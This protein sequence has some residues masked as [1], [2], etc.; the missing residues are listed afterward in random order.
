MKKNKKSDENTEKNCKVV[1][2]KNGPYLVS[3]SLP[4]S[5]EIIVCDH[6]G[7]PAEWKKGEKYPNQENYALCRCGK[8][9]NKPY[10]DSTHL[11]IKF[12]GTE[13]ASRK[14]YLEQAEKLS[15]PGLDLTDAENLCSVARFCHRAGGTWNLTGNSDN[16]K[17]K[18]LAIKE[19]C[20]CPSGRLVAWNKKTGKPI[21]IKFEPSISLAEE[22]DKKCSGPIRLKGGVPLESEN[23]D[24]YEIRNR[25]TLCRCGK[26]SNKPFCDGTHISERFNDGDKSVNK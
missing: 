13:T 21:E 11:K 12:N 3:G 24:K 23:G 5:K 7:N 18:E 22:P 8:S 16:P 2:S 1:V 4:L 6:E 17:S 20:N 25:I 10:C 9:K 19:A 15:G 14:K 26:S